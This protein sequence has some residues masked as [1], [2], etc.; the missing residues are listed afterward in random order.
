ML[1]FAGGLVGCPADAVE[2]VRVNADYVC[3]KCGGDGAVREFIDFLV[4][5]SV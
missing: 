4:S 2:Q 1:H 5:G 3:D